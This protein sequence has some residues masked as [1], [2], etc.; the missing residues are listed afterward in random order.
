MMSRRQAPIYIG[1][2]GWSYPHWEGPFYP[3][4][5]R[6]D[7][8]LR[9]YAQRFS[10]VEINSTFYRLPDK[11]TIRRWRAAVPASF[12]FS[13]KA[14]RF[15]THMKKL[16]GPTRGLTSFLDRLSGLGPTLGP[17]LFQL[18]PRWG[19]DARRLASFLAALDSELRVAFEFRD[20]SW[21]RIETYEL[22]TRHRAAFC[23]YDLARQLSPKAM[24]TDFVYVRLHGPKDAYRGQYDNDTLCGW[25][26]AFSTWSRRGKTIYCYFD[27]DEH[28]YA[29]QDAQ[30]LQQMLWRAECLC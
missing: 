26:D 28:G 8:L 11:A 24:T 6:G 25:A 15:I 13:V 27:N 18:P 20:P 12:V 7:A 9:Y 5:L 29:A 21:F 4:K 16:K 22:L 3:E 23:M 1:T 19:F 30:R 17:V 2:S 10:T 14:S